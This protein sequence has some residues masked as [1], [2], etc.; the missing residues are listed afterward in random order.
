MIDTDYAKKLLGLR[1]QKS[2]D[3]Q[4]SELSWYKL[5]NGTEEVC[6]RVLP[7]MPNAR[8]PGKIIHNHYNIPDLTK[9]LCFKTHDIDCPLCKLLDEYSGRMD[10][11]DWESRGRCY[12]NILVL[13]DPSQNPVL[14]PKKP[15]IFS[16]PESVLYWLLEY[17]IDPLKGD[18]T[19][20]R[21]GNNV[22]MHR[23]TVGG[24]IAKNPAPNP[25][26]I[27]PTEAEI[28]SILS[29][30]TD[31]EAIWR[32]PDDVWS[33]KMYDATAKLRNVIENRI[34][35]LGSPAP[36]QAS[37]TS[38]DRPSPA[39]NAQATAAGATSVPSPQANVSG[40]PSNAPECFSSKAVYNPKEKKCVM[41]AFEYACSDAISKAGA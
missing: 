32:K 20:P 1:N 6:I 8:I 13:R 38:S 23:E 34:M 5:P 29:K 7:T 2:S 33:K 27:A 4:R 15:V 17:A 14:D 3:G 31:F 25:G 11:Q 12:M 18:I 24:K 30:R 39:P 19:D 40:R 41:C 9:M 37:H 36:S 28:E 10:T 21:K 22:F 35:N 26:P 16:G